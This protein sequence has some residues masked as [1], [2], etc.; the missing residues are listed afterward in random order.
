MARKFHNLAGWLRDVRAAL[1]EGDELAYEL[2]EVLID[3]DDLVDPDVSTSAAGV[4]EDELLDADSS[5]GVGEETQLPMR[6]IED[7][8]ADRTR[9]VRVG[10]RGQRRSDGV[11]EGSSGTRGE[12]PDGR[13]AVLARISKRAA[14]RVVGGT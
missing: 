3:V 4:G 7:V 14:K 10:N 13:S 2:G 6:G 5:E 12:R 11:L 8:D 9:M 1:A